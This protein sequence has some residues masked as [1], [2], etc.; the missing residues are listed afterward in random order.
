MI[1]KLNAWLNEHPIHAL[2]IGTAIGMVT[3][4]LIV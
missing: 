2:L 4:S 1:R 3:I